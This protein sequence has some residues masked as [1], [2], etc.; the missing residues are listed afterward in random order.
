MRRLATQT[1][2]QTVQSK[3][4]YQTICEL[5]SPLSLAPTSM[6]VS[7]ISITYPEE[8]AAGAIAAVGGYLAASKS[9]PIRL[10]VVD[11]VK[12]IFVDKIV[13]IEEQN[14][15]TR[16]G[17]GWQIEAT[18]LRSWTVSLSWDTGVTILAW[19]VNCGI[20]ALPPAISHKMT[21]LPSILDSLNGVSVCPEL[22]YLTHD[23]PTCGGTSNSLKNLVVKQSDRATPGKKCSQC[24][25]YLPVDPRLEAYRKA[26][27]TVKRAPRSM[28]VAF[29]GHRSKKSG[30]QNECRGCKNF[31]INGH[32]NIIRT[33]DQ[34]HESSTLTRERKLLLRESEILKEFKERYSKKG[35]RSFVWERFGRRCF[36]CGCKV[37]LKNYQMDHTRPLAYL[38]PLDEHATCLCQPCNNSKKD[39]FPVD[40]YSPDELQKLS[41]IIGLSLTELQMRS[42]NQTELSRIRA[43]LVS[44]VD[45]WDPRLFKSIADRVK[46]HHPD[47]ELF[48]ELKKISRAKHKWL[49]A[50]LEARPPAI[51]ETE[52]NILD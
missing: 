19:G 2:G 10:L 44:F 22:F 17:T 36:K 47:I 25:R 45:S 34:F 30:Y 29:H 27:N 13:N 26:N 21:T 41:R 12:S 1:R 50:E 48:A 37:T 16:F 18:A 52:S 43:D 20:A 9:T 15:W 31:E 32:F 14:Y 7:S 33:P 8:V 51:N 28:V 35:L 40:F 49:I 5:G 42:V 23:S 11:N 24:Q 39:A 38:W 4:D 46:E 6:G 3:R